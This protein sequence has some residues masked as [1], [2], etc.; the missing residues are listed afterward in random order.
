MSDVR[1]RPA[2]KEDC[3]TIAALYRISSDG[4]ADYIWTQSAGPG[5]D[6]LEV[7]RKHYEREGLAFSYENCVVVEIAGQ[8]VGMLVAFPMQVDPSETQS[9]PVLAPYSK[10]EEDNSYYICGMALFP[11]FRGRGVGKQLLAL[12]EQH[13]REKGFSKLSL[14]VFE[15][16]TGAK[17][18]YERSGYREVA[19]E[20]VYPHPLIHHTGDAVLMVKEI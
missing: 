20:P 18:L 2:T 7:G 19:R 9:D 5:E 15:Q 1:I 6:I 3:G 14:I 8:V 4:V 13:A 12:A 10:L 11:A 16:N 17:R